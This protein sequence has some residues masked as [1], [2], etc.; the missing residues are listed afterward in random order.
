[1]C[2]EEGC[3]K[4]ADILRAPVLWCSARGGEDSTPGVESAALCPSQGWES[5]GAASAGCLL[6]GR[7]LRVCVLRPSSLEAVRASLLSTS[8]CSGKARQL[9][10]S[11]AFVTK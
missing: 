9:F 2:L 6:A 3:A 4:A 7:W 1:M 8:R 11:A 10:P 5:L